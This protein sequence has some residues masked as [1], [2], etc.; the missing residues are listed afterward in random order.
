MRRYLDRLRRSYARNRQE[1]EQATA[2]VLGL[3]IGITLGALSFGNPDHHAVTARQH[4]PAAAAASH[5]ASPQPGAG[6][7][8]AAP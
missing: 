3:T 6:R 4:R 7:Q 5:A 1:V 8:F 2:C